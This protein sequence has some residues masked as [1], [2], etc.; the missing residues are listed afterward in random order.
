MFNI[1]LYF[2]QLFPFFHLNR[3][4]FHR[5]VHKTKCRDHQNQRR[6][7]ELHSEADTWWSTHENLLLCQAERFMSTGLYMQTI[8]WIMRGHSIMVCELVSVQ[9]CFKNILLRIFSRLVLHVLIKY[10]VCLLLF[11]CWIDFKRICGKNCLCD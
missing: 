6:W 10:L 11:L 9:D 7:Y 8:I 1:N 4:C 2:Y 5:G 3:Y